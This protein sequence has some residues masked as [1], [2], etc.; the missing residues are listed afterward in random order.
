MGAGGG[1]SGGGFIA[2][3]FSPRG[4]EIHYERHGYEF[5]PPL[6]KV[7]YNERAKKLLN[8]EIGGNIEGFTDDEGRV[9]R[10]N[11]ETHDFGKCAPDGTI[12]TL[13]KTPQRY[14]ERQAELYG[15]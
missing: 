13:Y 2:K 4:L 10:Y 15:P 14:W 12:I 11:T 5:Y 8:S 7:E 1:S 6:S 9:W 3:G